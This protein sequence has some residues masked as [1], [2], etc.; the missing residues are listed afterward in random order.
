MCVSVFK[1]SFELCSL[2]AVCVARSCGCLCLDGGS[3]PE[4]LRGGACRFLF[5][6]SILC[7]CLWVFLLNLLFSFLVSKA[8]VLLIPLF[9]LFLG[10]GILVRFAPLAIGCRSTKR[11]YPGC[12]LGGALSLLMYMVLYTCVLR[13]FH[14]FVALV[15]PLW[16]CSRLNIR[17]AC[18]MLEI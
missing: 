9:P 11:G 17:I 14:R 6:F 4:P 18:L 15:F 12:L 2:C 10:A 13:Y 7:C 3:Q 8:S 5:A 16:R 1:S